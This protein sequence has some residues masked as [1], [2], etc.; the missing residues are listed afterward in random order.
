MMARTTVRPPSPESNT[1]MGRA[2]LTGSPPQGPLD[3]LLGELEVGGP[4]A[5]REVLP[6]PVGEEAHHVARLDPTGHP[7]G[8][9][10]HRARRDPGENALTSRQVAGGAEGIGRRYQ[11]LPV[12]HRLVEDRRDEPLVERAQP[13]DELAE[14]GL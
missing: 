10:H 11:E 5:R 6:S 9:V 1:P 12:E 8:G 13:V 4:R 14:F 7:D 3:L 2:S